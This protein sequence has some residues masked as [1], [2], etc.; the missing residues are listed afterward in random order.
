[1]GRYICLSNCIWV[2]KD[3]SVG[4]DIMLRVNNPLK[5]YDMMVI[6]GRMVLKETSDEEFFRFF[7]EIC[8]NVHHLLGG[9]SNLVSGL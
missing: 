5:R 8:P 7:Q 9:S 2:K 3:G 1:M 4:Y 6:Y